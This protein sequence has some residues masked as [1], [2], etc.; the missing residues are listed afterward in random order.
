MI[1]YREAY[2][3]GRPNL[4][5]CAACSTVFKSAIDCRADRSVFI[6][7][8]KVFI[9]MKPLPARSTSDSIGI[10]AIDTLATLKVRCGDGGGGDKSEGYERSDD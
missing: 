7:I 5:E 8:R 4:V 9:E 6:P 1:S 3:A 10:S 2:K